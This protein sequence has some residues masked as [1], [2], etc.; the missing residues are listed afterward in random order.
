MILHPDGRIE[1]TP[2]EI[3]KYKELISPAS[4]PDDEER[5]DDPEAPSPEELQERLVEAAHAAKTPIPSGL[6]GITH[7]LVKRVPACT[8]ANCR[9]ARNIFGQAKGPDTFYIKQ[10]GSVTPVPHMP[11]IN[12]DCGSCR[13]ATKYLR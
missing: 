1:G 11:D 9:A 2:E 13:S 4:C 10:P 6:A 5:E 3:L 8:C 7:D 12:C